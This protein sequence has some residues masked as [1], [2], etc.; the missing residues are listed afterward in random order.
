MKSVAKGFTT[1]CHIFAARSAELR[2]RFEAI[3]YL[4]GL[5]ARSA[6][7]NLDRDILAAHLFPMLGVRAERGRL[8]LP[9]DDKVDQPL[10]A[11]ISDEFW[12]ATLGGD[13]STVGKTLTIET[14][15]LTPCSRLP[16]QGDCRWWGRSRM[17]SRC[18]GTPPTSAR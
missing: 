1:R 5:A 15:L 12:R 2:I 6:V 18:S 11:V 4:A 8:I 9:S 16:T 17:A 14:G 13:A 10:V 3:D 7:R